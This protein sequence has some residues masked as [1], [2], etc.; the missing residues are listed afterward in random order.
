MPST[1]EVLKAI[2]EEREY[3]IARWS[4]Q[5]DDI[6]QSIIDFSTFME[7][8]TARAKKAQVGSMYG[9]ESDLY[10]LDCLRK[11]IALGVACLEQHGIV[12][13]SESQSAMEAAIENG[14]VS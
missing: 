10:A 7:E 3:Q 1:A 13:R 9:P 12:P 11:A 4:G 2:A 5:E 6:A 8:Y 14:L